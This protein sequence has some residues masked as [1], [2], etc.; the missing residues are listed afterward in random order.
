MRKRVD[1]C[2]YFMR[3]LVLIFI[4]SIPVISHAVAIEGRV[5][6]E[7][8]PLKDAKVYVYKTYESIVSDSPSLV[9]GPTDENGVY[10]FQLPEGEY[11]FTA[12]GNKGGKELYAYHGNNPIKVEA[13]NIWLTFMANQVRPPDY[14]K[15]ETSLR[16]VVT[17][18]GK[19]VKDAYVALYKPDAKIFKGLGFRTESVNAEGAFYFS[20]PEGKY[21]VIARKTEGEKKIRPVKK[22][23]LFCYYAQNPVEVKTDKAARIEVPC[24]PRGDRISF[25]DSPMIKTNDYVTTD[26]LADRRRFGIKGRVTDLEGKP[27]G[28]LYVLAYRRQAPVFLLFHMGG[29]SEYISESDKDGNYFIPMED[30]D[31]DF[32]VVALNTLGGIMPSGDYVL[33]LYEGNP[34]HVVSFRKGQVVDNIDIVVGKAL[35]DTIRYELKGAVEM[36]HKVYETDSVIDRDTVWKGN[37]LISGKILVKRGVTLKIEPGTVVKFKKIDRDDNEVGDGEI[38]VEGRIIARGTKER[39][40]IFASA[41]KNPGLKDWSYVLLLTSVTDNAFEYCEFRNAFTGVQV[42]YSTAKITDCLFENNNEGLRFSRA[43]LALQY[44]SFVN[45]DLGFRFSRFEGNVTVTN[46]LITGN[47]VGILFLRPH[48]NSVD[49]DEPQTL[50][51]MP[52]IRDN[53]IYGNQ[54]YN[55]R[56]GD[57]S[58][59]DVD[60]VKNWWGS[61]KKEDI[62]KMFFDKKDDSELGALVYSPFLAEPVKV[63]GVRGSVK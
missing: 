54:K 17:Y 41:E 37:I 20:V 33:G 58:T 53:N 32:H 61:V 60:A 4:L 24:Y 18:K 26:D 52:L 16:G 29:G 43:N 50:V 49:F 47:G 42:H 31:G 10:R 45:N 38:M 57:R 23:D 48:L 30:A 3:L 56:M 19:V 12:R 13:E 55:S 21:V 46:N 35:T 36:E 59:L 11:L 34:M 14:S 40:I 39:R 6:D 7:T 5:F 27:A 28:G 2:R 15:G 44:N 22:G 51:K 25:I 8:G 9:S 1:L 62:E 63:A